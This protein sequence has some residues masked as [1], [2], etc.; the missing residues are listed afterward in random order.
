[1]HI[2]ELTA[3]DKYLTASCCLCICLQVLFFRYRLRHASLR[4]NLISMLINHLFVNINSVLLFVKHLAIYYMASASKSK[5]QL[6]NPISNDCIQQQKCM[7]FVKLIKKI[8]RGCAITVNIESVMSLIRPL[9]WI[10]II[11][12]VLYVISGLSYSVSNYQL[13]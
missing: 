4:A 8:C 1:V 5:W 2:I 11:I 7:I 6:R 13:K 12:I 10:W 9:I 3:I